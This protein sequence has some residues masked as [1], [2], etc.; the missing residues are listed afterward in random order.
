MAMSNGAKA[1]R[2]M[3]AGHRIAES[4]L[5]QFCRQ[6]IFAGACSVRSASSPLRRGSGRRWSIRWRCRVGSGC[7]V[8]ESVAV[9][10]QRSV[11]NS[12]WVHAVSVPSCHT[13]A[14]AWDHP[15]YQRRRH[16]VSLS[17]ARGHAHAA[18]GQVLSGLRGQGD[19]FAKEASDGGDDDE[20]W[21]VGADGARR[22]LSRASSAVGFCDGTVCA[23]G[24]RSEASRSLHSRSRVV[25]RRGW[26]RGSASAVAAHPACYGKKSAVLVDQ[27]RN[28][29]AAACP[30]V[31][32]GGC[33]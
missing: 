24:R 25:Q 11:S 27:R 19:A 12:R 3:F 18:A 4:W 26:A 8:S 1:L 17:S 16:G 14:I 22:G 23:S 6:S 13:P 10:R 20:R 5:R 30:R 7:R 29:V 31:P 32:A 2:G 33:A 15:E 21:R 9:D 28:G